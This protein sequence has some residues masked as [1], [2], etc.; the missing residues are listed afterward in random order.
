MIKEVNGDILGLES[1]NPFTKYLAYYDKEY[2]GYIEYN[3]IYDT[4]DIVNVFVYEKFRNKG[5]ATSLLNYLIKNNL[6]KKNI[7]LEV[8]TLNDIAIKLYKKLGFRVVAIRRGYYK[9]I[10]GYL[11]ELIL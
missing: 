8:S 11:M 4:I 1:V 6:D 5:V 9:G 10:D 7:T 3:D 2:L